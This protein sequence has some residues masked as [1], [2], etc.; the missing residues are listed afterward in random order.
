MFYHPDFNGTF[1]LKSVLPAMFPD[2]DELDYKKLDVQ[3][4]MMAMGIYANLHKVEDPK[5]RQV[6]RESLLAYCKLDT[7]AMVKIWQRLND[8]CR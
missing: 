5:E 6:I 8:V 2:D 7:L 3:D 4:G 1:S